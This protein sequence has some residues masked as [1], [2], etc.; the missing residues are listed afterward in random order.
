MFLSKWLFVLLLGPILFWYM[1]KLGYYYQTSPVGECTFCI[2]FIFKAEDYTERALI[3]RGCLAVISWLENKKL[4]TKTLLHRWC[5]IVKYCLIIFSEYRQMVLLYIK[6]NFLYL[7]QA[8]KQLAAV[9]CTFQA[10][11]LLPDIP[12]GWVYFLCKSGRLH[13]KCTHPKGMS[14][15]IIQAC[16]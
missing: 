11:I 7:P 1:T 3:H 4:C 15:S 10:W 6:D 9:S 5:F 2:T 13:R 12:C 14:G 8:P 16:F